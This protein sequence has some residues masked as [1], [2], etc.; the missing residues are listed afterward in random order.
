MRGGKTYSPD[1][2]PDLNQITHAQRASID[3][4]YR[5][6]SEGL[7]DAVVAEGVCAA[8]RC[9]RLEERCTADAADLFVFRLIT[10]QKKEGGERTRFELGVST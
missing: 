10:R 4:T 8:E 1:D 3:G 2:S 5:R 7:V 6:V 9:C